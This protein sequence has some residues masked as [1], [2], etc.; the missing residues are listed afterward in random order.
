[1]SSDASRGPS[2]SGVLH[3]YAPKLVAF[4]FTP[5]ADGTNKIN[6]LIFVGGLTDGLCTVPYVSKL[7]N[8]LENTEWS[9]FSV[10]LSSSYSGWGVGSLD[11]DVEEIGQCV[12]FIRDLKASRQPGAMTKAGKIVIMGHSTG[13]QDV[14]H[15]LYSPNPVPQKEFDFGLQHMVRPELD[16]AILQAP[17]SD[18]ESLLA[19]IESSSQPDEL[20]K[21]YDQL[22]SSAQEQPYTADKNDSILPMNLTAKLS[23]PADAPLSARRF[24]SLVSPHSP[25]SPSDDDLFSSDLSDKRLQETF[26]MV[27]TQGMVKSKLLALYSGKDE[28]CPHWVDKE[29]LLQRWQQATEAGGAQWDAENSGVVPGA[30]HNV[31]DEGQQDL[32]DRVLRYLQTL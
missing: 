21:I 18:R 7:A 11:R 15:Y 4:E 1:M 28:Y 5:P 24:L 3:E 29:K 13:S 20:R 32:I 9:V 23:Y 27:G 19:I 10:L 12:R 30:S 16:G 22:V 25:D 8:A 31:R 17:V 26:G 14:L 2:H 6:S